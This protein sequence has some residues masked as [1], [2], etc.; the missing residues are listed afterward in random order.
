MYLIEPM[1][2]TFDEALEY[3]ATFGHPGAL[4]FDAFP[5]TF[6][7]SGGSIKHPIWISLTFAGHGHK[8][9]D[10]YVYLDYHRLVIRDGLYRT[11]YALDEHE[12]AE[13]KTRMANFCRERQL[14]VRVISNSTMPEYLEKAA[15]E[16]FSGLDV[17]WKIAPIMY[18]KWGKPGVAGVEVSA[19][20]G[21]P[22]PI[23]E[24]ETF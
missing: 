3:I 10:H 23:P 1:I 19:I 18:R 5:Q 11:K 20:D 15:Q 16:F 9:F 8:S 24:S 17:K 4:F 6:V 7:L 13:L 12:H 21:L 22:V 14:H 2:H